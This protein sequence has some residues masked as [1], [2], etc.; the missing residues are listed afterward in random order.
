MRKGVLTAVP[1]KNLKAG[2]YALDYF[3]Q[4]LIIEDGVEQNRINGEGQM[5][6]GILV[7]LLRFKDNSAKNPFVKAMAEVQILA[8]IETETITEEVPMTREEVTTTPLDKHYYEFAVGYVLGKEIAYTTTDSGQARIGDL[9]TNMAT[10][11]RILN[12][13][14]EGE[15]L[16]F[17]ANFHDKQIEQGAG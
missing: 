16:R 17:I 12:N 1:A 15:K 10:A 11:L 2:D 3:G 5:K 7:D 6:N 9:A 14:P 13:L 8:V 4:V